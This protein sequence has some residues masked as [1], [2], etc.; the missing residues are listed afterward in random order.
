MKTYV[1]HT[2]RVRQPH[3]KQV[4]LIGDFNNWHSNAH[5]MVEVGPDLWERIVDLPPGKHRYAFFVIDDLRVSEGA[6]RS[7]IVGNGSVLWVP[8]SPDQ[9]IS[10]A[11]H[12]AMSL[13]RVA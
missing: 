2:I 9:S 7:R 12:P 5:P 8:E 6:L 4:S 11:A 13:A 10:V 1:P 3:A